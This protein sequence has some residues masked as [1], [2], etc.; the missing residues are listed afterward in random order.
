MGIST[1]RQFSGHDKASAF[2][3]FGTRAWNSSSPLVV[4]ESDAVLH[5][6]DTDFIR[7]AALRWLNPLTGIASRK[8]RTPLG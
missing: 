6:T 2:Q 3:D 7:F 1:A 4:L 5:T 8:A